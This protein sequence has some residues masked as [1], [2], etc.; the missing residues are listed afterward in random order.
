[1]IWSRVSPAHPVMPLP[2]D[3]AR[4]DH[5][6]HAGDRC[7]VVA[8]RTYH[9]APPGCRHTRRRSPSRTGGGTAGAAS[10]TRS[11]RAQRPTRQRRPAQG[12]SGLAARR[13][14]EDQAVAGNCDNRSRVAAHGTT[15]SRSPLA[16]LRRTTTGGSAT[17]APRRRH[18]D[19]R[20]ADQQ[21]VMIQPAAIIS[22]LR[23]SARA[24]SESADRPRTARG[25]AVAS[26][27]G[28][29]SARNFDGR[30]VVEP[31]T[32]ARYGAGLRVQVYID[33]PAG[34][35][36]IHR[37]SR[38]PAEASQRAGA[39]CRS[40]SGDRLRI[41]TSEMRGG[42][43]SAVSVVSMRPPRCRRNGC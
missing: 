28:W 29:S 40:V 8:T 35:A 11:D 17:T 30:P 31:L 33:S 37:G 27:D 7:I 25:S 18:R 9:S 15:R 24:T 26:A 43:V 5:A 22:T 19:P 10:G 1:M 32:C 42:C 41:R 34:Q 39:G 3:N 2:G 4:R 20:S 14:A 38:R 21:N 13:S 12:C 6:T 23:R 16:R 36:L